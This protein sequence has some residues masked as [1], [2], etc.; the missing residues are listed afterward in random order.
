MT[1]PRLTT[2]ADEAALYRKIADDWFDRE[3]AGYADA[4]T[5]VAAIVER[6]GFAEGAEPREVMEMRAA[7]QEAHDFL[8]RYAD[9]DCQ[10]G[11]MVPNEAMS[12]QTV[13]TQALGEL[14]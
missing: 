5:D 4:L 13:I 1:D 8:D 2:A 10:D 7:L 14:P 11:R 6:Y 9:A 12:L 3:A